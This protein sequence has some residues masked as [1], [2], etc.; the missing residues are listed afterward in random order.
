MLPRGGAVTRFSLN[1]VLWSRD[2]CEYWAV[3]MERI[4]RS[5]GLGEEKKDGR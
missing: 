4:P 2:S 3:V 1:L 5:M